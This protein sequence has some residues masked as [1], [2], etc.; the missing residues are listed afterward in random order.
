[1]NKK[2]AENLIVFFKNLTQGTMK[3]DHICKNEEDK[4]FL[5]NAMKGRRG[6]K[7]KLDGKDLVTVRSREEQDEIERRIKENIK[8]ET[9]RRTAKLERVEPC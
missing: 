5:I 3:I 4:K 7:S 2:E 9:Q 6:L 8:K 1:M